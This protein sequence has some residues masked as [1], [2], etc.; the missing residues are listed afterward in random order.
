MDVVDLDGT[1]VEGAGERCEDCVEV[2]WRSACFAALQMAPST[3][4]ISLQQFIQNLWIHFECT[5][6]GLERL[7]QVGPVQ[8]F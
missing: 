2:V 7:V 3:T 6:F 5:V 8:T 1:D 4:E